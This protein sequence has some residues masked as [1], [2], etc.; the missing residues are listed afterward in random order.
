V[1]GHITELVA[2]AV[3]PGGSAALDERLVYDAKHD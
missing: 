1:P 3:L 2:M